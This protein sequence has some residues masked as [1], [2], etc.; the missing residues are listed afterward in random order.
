MIKSRLKVGG[1]QHWF[2]LARNECCQVYL[3]KTH[4]TWRNISLAFNPDKWNE[5]VKRSA[6]L[7]PYDHTQSWDCVFIAFSIQFWH[8]NIIIIMRLMMMM[9]MDLYYLIEIKTNCT[10][11]IMQ[12]NSEV[13][14]KINRVSAEQNQISNQY[15]FM[16]RR[17]ILIPRVVQ[18][19]HLFLFPR[20]IF[21]IFWRTILQNNFVQTF[22]LAEIHEWLFI[23]WS[24]PIK[25]DNLISIEPN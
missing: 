12:S 19:I 15:C 20:G 10:K 24:P 17:T 16:L 6:A 8:I 7:W 21:G 14:C 23:Y 2:D 25:I 18:S 5:L 1:Y 22:H 13:S 9:I 3:P 11:K 4:Y